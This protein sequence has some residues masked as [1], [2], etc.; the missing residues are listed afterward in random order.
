M[1][2]LV[3]GANG[4]VGSALVQEL[5]RSYTVRSAV[6]SA[7][8]A[9]SLQSRVDP[10]VVGGI[11]P[12]TW[13]G[14]ALSGVDVVVHLA[15]R[16]HV[17]REHA[18]E[19]LTEFRRVNV[20]GTERLARAAAE[21]GV[22]RFVYIS[23]VGVIGDR[24]GAQPLTEDAPPRPRTPY[25]L[26]K[27]EAEQTLHIIGHETGMEIVILRP[28]LVYGPGAPGNFARL[29]RWVWRGLPL[30]LGRVQN[31]RSMVS[32]RNL[33]DAIA[34]AV[35]HTRAAGE[36]FLVADDEIHSTPELIRTLARLMERRASLIPVPVP[37]LRIGA[38][39]VGRVRE[40]EQLA[41]SLALS[42]E[43]I[44]ALL[45]WAPPQTAEEGLRESVRRFVQ[46]Q[47]LASRG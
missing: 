2:I 46:D 39:C 26:S 45:R 14:N 13:W 24:S 28:P 25:A 37:V 23:S 31:R 34:V 44:H 41:G 19:P 9:V 16:V 43:K 22:R 6:R 7:E 8:G 35:R 5:G 42:T 1:R 33:V 18:R 4:F 30:P 21:Q 36:V 29:L 17:L 15:A 47:D 40:L 10:V 3:T 20:A 27:W 12:D 11:G 38:G 32:V